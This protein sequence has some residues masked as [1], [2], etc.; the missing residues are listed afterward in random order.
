MASTR[1]TRM[2]EFYRECQRKGYTDMLDRTQSLNAKV[3]ATDLGLDYG[4]IVAFYDE[5]KR[6][7]EQV[8]AE[9]EEARKRAEEAKKRRAEEERRRAVDG[10]LLLT[11][12]C[13]GESPDVHV[14]IRS[15]DSI[16]YTLNDDPAKNE[17]SP[18]I[19]AKK[20][21]VIMLD[22]QPSQA[23]YTSATV[24]GITTGGVHFT[25]DGYDTNFS[26]NGKGEIIVCIARQEYILKEVIITDYTKDKF[27]RD[28]QYPFIVKKGVIQ[29]YQDTSKSEYLMHGVELAALSGNYQ[30][31]SNAA[32]AA[33]DERRLPYK[34]CKSIKDLLDRIVQGKFPP[35]EE[36]IY[37]SASALAH[38]SHAEDLKRAIDLF[39]SIYEYKDS[40]QRIDEL[41]IKYEEVLK[42]E[43]IEA[44]IRSEARQEEFQGK[45]KAVKTGFNVVS[46]VINLIVTIILGFV[47]FATLTVPET[48]VFA[49]FAMIATI[50]SIPGMGQLVLRDRYKFAQRVLRWIIVVA[51]LFVGLI[52]GAIVSGLT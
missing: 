47:S 18:V 28:S 4:D 20:T 41:K 30:L 43:K 2:S 8:C 5:A 16:Y 22:Y 51:I 36:E 45:V 7:Y 50:V 42:N 24:G 33:A 13:Q 40:A 26:S 49:I 27:K 9:K 37:A 14:Y 10:Q 25:Q 11:L 38:A 52:V 39:E 32:S 23:V 35:T 48:F 15:D 6:C 46:V 21:G 3:I 1:V 34:T 17:G 29:C 31:A 12:C 44:I 19:K